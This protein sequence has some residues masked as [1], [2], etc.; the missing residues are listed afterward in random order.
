MGKRYF[1]SDFHFGDESYKWE[2]TQFKSEEE[3][4]TNLLN[5]IGEWANKLNKDASNEIWILGDWGD[6]NFL[7][8]MDAFECKKVFVYGNHDKQVDLETFELY[9]DEVYEYPQFLS[10]KLVVSHY[11]VAVWD[12]CVNV[13]G[14]LHKCEIVPPNYISCSVDDRGYKL[15]T[16]KEIANAFSRAP[17]FTAK[18]LWEPWADLPQ[19][20]LNLDRSDIVFNP[21]TGII[22][23]AASRCKKSFDTSKKF[24][25]KPEE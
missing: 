16:E 15:V 8:A 9:F 25:L 3:H 22:D 6:I 23:I 10:Q 21:A 5:K 11:P 17:K 1:I 4:T 19:R 20:N 13:H 7:W 24:C 12:E 18:F 14:H 2:R